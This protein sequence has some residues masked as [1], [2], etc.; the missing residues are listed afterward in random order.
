MSTSAYRL[1]VP[2]NTRRYADEVGGTVF[3]W[4]TLL[5]NYE[6]PREV[7]YGF[8]VRCTK[9]SDPTQP[10]L[11]LFGA[12]FGTSANKHVIFDDGTTVGVWWTAAWNV[13]S[14]FEVFNQF[15][16]EESVLSSGPCKAYHVQ[17]VGSEA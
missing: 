3:Q 4:R 15:R 6:P 7:A 2:A 12:P 8:G 1:I 17:I 5:D 16:S 13:G 10:A 11:V 9:P 14:E